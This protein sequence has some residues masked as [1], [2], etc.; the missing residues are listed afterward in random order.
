MSVHTKMPKR[1]NRIFVGQPSNLG[2]GGSSPLG[3]LRPLRPSGYFGLP[4][5]NPIIPPNRPYHRPLNYPKYV[6]DFDPNVHVKVFKVAI[7][8]NGETKYA[9]IVNMFTFTLRDIVS[10]WC[11]NYM[12]DYPN[13]TFV[14]L[15]LAFCKRFKTIQNDEQM[16][17]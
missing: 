16:Y 2:G 10:N 17:L 9:K 6:K 14:E 11:N 15:Q 1:V 5:M 7:K 8:A 4:M 13:C 3:P 12:G